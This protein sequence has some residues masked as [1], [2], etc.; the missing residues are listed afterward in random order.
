[1]I[2]KTGYNYDAIT[3]TVTITASFAKKASQVDSEEYEIMR[4]L[5]KDYPSLKVVREE[6]VGKAQLTYKMMEEFINLHR[7][8][9][10]LM[11]AFKGAKTLSKFHSMPFSFV[12]AWFEKTFPYYKDGNYE[13]DADGFIVEVKPQTNGL[14]VVQNTTEETADDQEEKASWLP[15]PKLSNVSQSQMLTDSQRLSKL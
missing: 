6:K 3:N 4:K 2:M 14:Q 12:K 1:M 8:S 15:L 13:M 9:V 5:R 7:N 10:E 11:N